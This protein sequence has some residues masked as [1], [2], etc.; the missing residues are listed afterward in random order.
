MYNVGKMIEQKD[1]IVVI[2]SQEANHQMAFVPTYDQR[3][4][5]TS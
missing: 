4:V 3:P 2:I 1:I 5:F